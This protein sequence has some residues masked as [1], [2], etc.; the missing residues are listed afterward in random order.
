MC[1]MFMFAS[2]NENGMHIKKVMGQTPR[3]HEQLGNWETDEKLPENFTETYP[4]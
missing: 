1:F 2:R 4:C 3:T